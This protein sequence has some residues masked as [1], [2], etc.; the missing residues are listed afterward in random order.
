MVYM[1]AESN[2]TPRKNVSLAEATYDRLKS[3]GRFGESFDDLINRVL[4]VFEKH[5]K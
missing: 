1:A 3:N 2:V 4:D 5:K